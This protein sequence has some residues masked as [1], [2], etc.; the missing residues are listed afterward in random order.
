[1]NFR[2][3][4]IGAGLSGLA[5]A[6]GLARLGAEVAVYERDPSPTARPQGYRIQLDPPGLIGLRQCLPPEVL[7]LCLAT[8]GTPLA[9]PRVL[10]H[11]L[12]PITEQAG[13]PAAYNRQTQAYPF[14]RATLREILLS[15]LPAA[16]DFGRECTGFD[17][18]GDGRIT[19]RFS[20]GHTDT[21][22]LLVGADGV[23]SAVRAAL[24]PHARVDDAGL[25]LIYGLVPLPDR[26]LLPDWVF[27][28]MFTV[29]TGPERTHIGLGP[30]LFDHSR[31]TAI[32]D[33]PTPVADYLATMVGARIDH[34]AMP[35]FPELRRLDSRALAELARRLIGDS[36]HPDLYRILDH[37]D[38]TTLFPLRIS[39]AAPVQPWSGS[40]VTLLGDAIHA[41]SPVL[42][43]GANTALRDAGELTTAIATART[44]GRRLNDAVTD[45]QRRMLAY[46]QPLVTASQRV[47]RARVGQ[48]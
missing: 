16:V 10:D 12:R 37:W 24:L 30:V 48:H 15:T 2:V 1:M 38:T 20:D 40:A 19:V 25:R 45:Y 7:Q 35:P 22:D 18:H 29:A 46:A 41:M 43:M 6:H 3:V 36:W 39:T 14:H 4:I 32:T 42:A 33:R 31:T 27:E 17:E 8:A 34:P 5:C 23:G 21:A 28:T 9:P 44:T 13:A 47:G 26:N 11:R